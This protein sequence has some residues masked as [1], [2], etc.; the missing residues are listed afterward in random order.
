MSL[1]SGYSKSEHEDENSTMKEVSLMSETDITFHNNQI[2]HSSE[3]S[4]DKIQQVIRL[5]LVKM[6]RH[7]EQPIQEDHANIMDRIYVNMWT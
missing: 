5:L 7:G 4:R 3:I 6:L 1:L 2:H